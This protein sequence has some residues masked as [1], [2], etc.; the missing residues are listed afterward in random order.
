M[1]VPSTVCTCAFPSDFVAGDLSGRAA[2]A[3][4]G[5]NATSQLTQQVCFAT[6]QL[7]IHIVCRWCGVLLQVT[8]QGVLMLRGQVRMPPAS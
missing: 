5:V 7:H 4:L 6:A 1:T 8:C 2:V 3:E